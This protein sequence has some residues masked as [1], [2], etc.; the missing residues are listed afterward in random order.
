[1]TYKL[2]PELKII[3]SP[4]VLLIDGEKTE[5]ENGNALTEQIFE[6]NYL[7]DSITAKENRIVIELK[8]NASVN[9]IPDSWTN[10]A[11]AVSFF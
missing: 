11:D 2:N 4:L 3:Q 9:V 10:K 1:M 5:Y 6:K 8:E 7:I